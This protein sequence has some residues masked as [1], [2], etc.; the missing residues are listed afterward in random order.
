VKVNLNFV[1][2][3]TLIFYIQWAIW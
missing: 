2:G 3:F 1:L